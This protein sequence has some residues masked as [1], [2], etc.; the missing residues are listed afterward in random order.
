MFYM[1]AYVH[2]KRYTH[3]H[4]HHELAQLASPTL[5]HLG[6]CSSSQAFVPLLLLPPTTAVISSDRSSH[7]NT[8][9]LPRVGH[10]VTKP[11]HGVVVFSARP[12]AAH[13]LYYGH[14]WIVAKTCP[15]NILIM[16]TTLVFVWLQQV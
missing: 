6:S 8:P 9:F 14:V 5:C 4:Q 10:V 12:C 11:T 2:V 16:V 15:T 1:A 3:M 13:L 7:P